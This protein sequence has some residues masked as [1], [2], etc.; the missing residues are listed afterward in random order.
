V[1]GDEDEYP[2]EPLPLGVGDY[3]QRALVSQFGPAWE[4]LGTAAEHVATYALPA[5]KSLPEAVQM[6]QN[7]LG[8]QPCEGSGELDPKK[9]KHIL[10]LAGTFLGGA[11]VLVRARMR[12]DGSQCAFELTVR[13]PNPALSRFVAS[14][15]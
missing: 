14:A 3:V 6:L 15:F 12:Q 1:E 9:A 2:L 13:S 7:T 10:Y 8:M 4:A 11:K 5:A